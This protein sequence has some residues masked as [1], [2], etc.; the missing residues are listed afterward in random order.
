[1]VQICEAEWDM[2]RKARKDEADKLTGI[3]KELL[4]SNVRLELPISDLA[5]VREAADM[6]IG[7]GNQIKLIASFEG[8][9]RVSKLMTIRSHAHSVRD[10]MR[11]VNGLTGRKYDKIKP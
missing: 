9:D 7:L 10:R 6:L 1:M 2:V 11:V 3:E 5:A 4:R 8:M